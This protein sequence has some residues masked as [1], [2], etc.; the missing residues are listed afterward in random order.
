HAPAFAAEQDRSGQR[1]LDRGGAAQRLPLRQAQLARPDTAGR[2]VDE[3]SEEVGGTPALGCDSS[4]LFALVSAGA[5][6]T[7]NLLQSKYKVNRG[8]AVAGGRPPGAHPR[9]AA[10]TQSAR[11]VP[12]HPTK[13]S[14]PTRRFRAGSP[15]PAAICTTDETWRVE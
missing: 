10:R 13:H 15:V 7:S 8:D 2:G 1:R 12:P 3:R 11:A 14:F 5:V 4:Y 6:S 9:R